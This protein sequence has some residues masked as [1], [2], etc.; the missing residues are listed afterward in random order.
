M[1]RACLAYLSYNTDTEIVYKETGTDFIDSH[2]FLD[3]A[4]RHWFSH[5]NVPRSED[6]DPRFVKTLARFKSSDSMVFSV[7]LLWLQFDHDYNVNLD[8]P[9]REAEAYPYEVASKL[10]LEDLLDILLDRRI[11]PYPNLDSS[12]VFASSTGRLNV[13]RLLLQHGAAIDGTISYESK[14]T[15]SALESACMGGHLAVV[16]FLMEN[17]AGIHGRNTPSFPPI[18]TAALWNNPDIIDL[19]LKKGVHV[20]ARDSREETACHV[21]AHYGCIGSTRCLIDAG[22]DLELRNN[23]GDT[24]LLTCGQSSY[25]ETINLLLDRGANARAKNK[26]GKTLLNIFEDWLAYRLGE[27]RRQRY[28][29]IVMRLRR[30]EQQSTNDPQQSDP[31]SSRQTVSHTSTS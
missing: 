24:V 30:Q 3:Y 15:K 23:N 22:C 26:K 16:E 29:G 9:D 12:L 4:C 13:A 27:E 6:A 2:P 8:D 5:A 31:S 11:G 14:S 1:S 21:A 25:P 17:G 19:L 18:H 10:G 28:E 7:C 20:N